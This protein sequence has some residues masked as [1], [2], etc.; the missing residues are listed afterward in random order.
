MMF[1]LWEFYLN[2]AHLDTTLISINFVLYLQPI[3]P[4]KQYDIQALSPANISELVSDFLIWRSESEFAALGEVQFSQLKPYVTQ[5]VETVEQMTHLCAQRYC[6]AN[7]AV[8]VYEYAFQ[9]RLWSP[10]NKE[11]TRMQ[12]L[13]WPQMATFASNHLQ[14]F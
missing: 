3:S 4:L 10:C 14:Y 11:V 8:S 6:Q 5:Q 2:P 9:K 1:W 13:D 12:F 7:F